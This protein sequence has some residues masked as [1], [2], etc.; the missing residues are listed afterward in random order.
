MI[1]RFRSFPIPTRNELF[2]WFDQ[3]GDALGAG[4]LIFAGCWLIAW[5]STIEGAVQ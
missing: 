4:I 1:A 3:T 2:R 5:A